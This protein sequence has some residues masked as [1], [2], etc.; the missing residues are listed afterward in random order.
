MMMLPY[1]YMPAS[2]VAKFYGLTSSTI[3]RYFHELEQ[4]P[5]Y[6]KAR[7]ILNPCGTR[8]YNTFVLEDFLAHRE[9]LKHKNLSKDLPP[10]DPKEI[11]WQRGYDLENDKLA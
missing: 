7:V 10:Y 4:Y 11:A 8:L 1:Q 6:K 3:I 2:K 5:R 9:A